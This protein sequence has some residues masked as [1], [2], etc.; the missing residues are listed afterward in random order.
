MLRKRQPAP[1]RVYLNIGQALRKDV[2]M[3]PEAAN[4]MAPVSADGSR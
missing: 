4:R 2:P 1:L 3:Y